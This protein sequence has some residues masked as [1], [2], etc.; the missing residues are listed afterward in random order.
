MVLGQEEGLRF[1]ANYPEYSC[2]MVTDA[3][4]IITSANTNLKKYRRKKA[5]K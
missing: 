4:K 1:I 2:I 3:G 5:R